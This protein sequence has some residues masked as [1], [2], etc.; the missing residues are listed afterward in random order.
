MTEVQ[1]VS[2]VLTKGE[3]FAIPSPADLAAAAFL[4]CYS[5]R[6][7]EAYRH[8]CGPISNGLATPASR[9]VFGPSAHVPQEAGVQDRLLGFFGRDLTGH[10]HPDGATE[11]APDR[12]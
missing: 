6:T 2:E 8:D 1:V 12:Y 10:R 11:R 3:A 9:C 4:A 7:F 5:N